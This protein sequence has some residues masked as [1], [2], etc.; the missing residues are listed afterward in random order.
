MKV[1]DGIMPKTT[2]GKRNKQSIEAQFALADRV[3][4]G[5]HKS[6]DEEIERARDLE[7]EHAVAL[8]KSGRAELIEGDEMIRQA[9]R[10]IG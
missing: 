2:Q 8:H 5:L 4:K 1:L 7:V 9:R 10:R 6:I 3:L